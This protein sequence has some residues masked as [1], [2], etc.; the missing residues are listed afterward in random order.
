[1]CVLI[2]A[3]TK[4]LWKLN[5]LNIGIFT[6]LLT[7]WYT[8]AHLFIF[9]EPLDLSFSA[10]RGNETVGPSDTRK[11]VNTWKANHSLDRK[12]YFMRLYVCVC[13]YVLP[14]LKRT[15]GSIPK[16]KLFLSPG[17]CFLP[18]QRSFEGWE[19]CPPSPGVTCTVVGKTEPHIR[20]R[21]IKYMH[22]PYS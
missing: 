18:R 4:Q 21:Y 16:Q 8:D 1:M 10:T 17:L 19:E 15:R 14:E 2:W 12:I 20:K 5:V 11:Q 7:F 3:Y 22:D 6:Y 13:V 9:V